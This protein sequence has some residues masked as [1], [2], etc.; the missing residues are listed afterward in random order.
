MVVFCSLP[1]DDFMRGSSFDVFG[2]MISMN[3]EQEDWKIWSREILFRALTIRNEERIA[4]GASHGLGRYGQRI[5][6]MDSPSL[7]GVK[8]S[9][10]GHPAMQ[11]NGKFPYPASSLYVTRDGLKELFEAVL[12][13]RTPSSSE[14]IVCGPDKPE[15]GEKEDIKI[16]ASKLEC[17]AIREVWSDKAYAYKIVD[18]P[19]SPD[20]SDLDEYVIVVR[21]RIDRKTR[22]PT[23][24]VDIKSV[25]LRDIIRT[26]LREVRTASLDEDK[27][28]VE[29]NVLYHF[30]PE[31]EAYRESV[32]DEETATPESLKHLDLL[33]LHLQEAYKSTAERLCS[34]L[35]RRKITYDLLWALFRPNMPVYTTCRGT[36]KP[37][38]VA[39]S[40]GGEKTTPQGEEYFELQ[41]RYFDFDGK[42]FGEAVEALAI[43][44]FHGVKRIE[45]L[46]AFPL[47][48]HP[49]D[50]IRER[51]I[52]SGR[53]FVSMLGSHYCQYDGTAFFQ[54]KNDLIRVPVNGRIMIDAPCFR[55][56]NPN[57]PR[58]QTMKPEVFDPWSGAT[59][60]KS[61]S[62][63]RSNGMN[64][65]EMEE[66]NL[67][68]CSPTLLGFS[69]FNKLWA[70][71]AVADI[72]D[73]EFS[74][75]PFDSL[76]IDEEKKQVAIALA[77]S[78][79]DRTGRPA[80]N[81]IIIG[82]GLGVIFLL[83]GHPGVGKTLTAEAIAERQE[84]PLY[85][86][87]A[88]ELSSEAAVLEEQLTRIFRIASFW[89]AILLLDEVDVFVQKHCPV[90]LERNRL[91]SIFLSDA[92]ID[93]DDLNIFAETKLNGR[94]IKNMIKLAHSLAT[95][96]RKPL[97]AGH[98]RTALKANGLSPPRHLPLAAWETRASYLIIHMPPG[99]AAHEVHFPE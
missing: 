38:C 81:D 53:T 82:K 55:N 17:K 45:N 66:D 34:L 20:V 92:E 16:R 30:L 15:N 61:V 33:I 22:E 28:V 42:V 71:F 68:I 35:S 54:Q 13:G 24:Y 72:S 73:I 49:E 47:V 90:Q 37:R 46:P 51:L 80:L 76:V 48:Y 57:Y 41:S 89:N 59:K 74:P 39:Y 8:L 88:G 2:G 64:P 26:V 99:R 27:P 98:I 91:V 75:L 12:E 83:H 96:D 79:V 5:L 40:F 21:T 11:Q 43:N 6:R 77:E 69:L 70:E 19:R 36:G 60:N 94:Q 44:K 78:R 56:V 14:G 86:I 84:R 93:E 10:H 29:R 95:W 65:T 32:T 87:S 62:R 67:L 31:L 52:A 50:N 23:V 25:G 63:V 3:S 7:E 97:S 58:L 4:Q 9:Y 18:S 1:S 85:S